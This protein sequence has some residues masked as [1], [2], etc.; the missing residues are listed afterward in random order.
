LAS[1]NGYQQVVEELL[2]ASIA[3]RKTSSSNQVDFLSHKDEPGRTALLYAAAKRHSQ[4][5]AVLLRQSGVEVED[6][7][8]VKLRVTYEGMPILKPSPLY[9]VCKNGMEEL[10]ESLL[11][12]Q[13][14]ADLYCEEDDGGRITVYATA[15]SGER[16]IVLALLKIG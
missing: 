9:M 6:P 8:P 5:A 12:H 10:A 1:R 16:D 4:T 7:L 2:N 3:K 13:A 14:S 11:R 15:Q